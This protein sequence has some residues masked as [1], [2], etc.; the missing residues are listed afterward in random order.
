V[1]WDAIDQSVLRTNFAVAAERHGHAPPTLFGLRYQQQ[2]DGLIG[3]CGA[4]PT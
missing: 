1:D 2:C 3:H 4:A